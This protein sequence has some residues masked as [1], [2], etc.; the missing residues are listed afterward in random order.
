MT[1]SLFLL[2][3]LFIKDFEAFHIRLLRISLGYQILWLLI[4]VSISF[5]Y[6]ERGLLFSG[7]KNVCFQLKVHILAIDWCPYNCIGNEASIAFWTLR[8]LKLT[9]WL[10]PLPCVSLNSRQI[11]QTAH[12]QLR[13]TVYRKSAHLLLVLK[14]IL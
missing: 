6:C 4:R 7:N 11:L 12:M 1:D 5:S 13:D 8:L 14:L 2:I 10:W 3:N 9:S